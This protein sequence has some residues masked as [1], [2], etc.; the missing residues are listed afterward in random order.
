MNPKKDQLKS[1]EE[2]P[3]SAAKGK[4]LPAQESIKPKT[5]FEGSAGK[6]SLPKSNC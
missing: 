5:E 3:G 6:G 4:K 1:K 2:F